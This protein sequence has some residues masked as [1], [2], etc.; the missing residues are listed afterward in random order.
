M[1]NNEDESTWLVKDTTMGKGTKGRGRREDDKGT[2]IWGYD[3]T[4]GQMVGE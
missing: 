2:M 1:S 4:P 3:D